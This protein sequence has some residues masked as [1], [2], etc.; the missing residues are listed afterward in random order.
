MEDSAC[1]NEWFNEDSIG[2]HQI[3]N[4]TCSQVKH[5]GLDEHAADASGAPRLAHVLKVQG[6]SLALQRVAKHSCKILHGN[7]RV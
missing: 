3:Q 6:V 1:D 5:T 7:E 4:S 2:D